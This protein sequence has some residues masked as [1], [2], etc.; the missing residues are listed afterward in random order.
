MKKNNDQ[1]SL[2]LISLIEKYD[3]FTNQHGECYISI[4]LN[5]KTQIW[6]LDSNQLKDWLLFKHYETF[7]NAASSSALNDALAVAHGRARFQS[8][9]IYTNNRFGQNAAYYLD[10]ATPEWQS[11]KMSPGEWT[12]NKDSSSCFIRTSSMR[13]LPLPTNGGDLSTFK[14]F[15][16]IPSQDDFLLVLAYLLECM[17]PDTPFPILLIDGEQGSAKSTTQKYI[18]SIIDP[19]SMTLRV[20]PNSIQDIFVAA[21]NDYI[22]SYNNLSDLSAK[23]QDAICCLSTGGGYSKRKLF[24]DMDESMTDIK[25][26]TILNGIGSIASAS[27]FLD[28][29]ILL[30]L[31]MIDSTTR[32]SEL[33]MQ[34]EFQ[35]AHPSLLGAL[36]DLFVNSL[37]IL[38]SIKLKETPR[39]SDFARLGSAMCIAL[40]QP[41]SKFIQIYNENQNKGNQE[42]IE[43]N[44]TALSILNL[45][46]RGKRE[47]IECNFIQLLNTLKRNEPDTT[48][49]PKNPRSLAS[50]LKRSA[51]ALRRTGIQ[52]YFDPTRRSNGY[53]VTITDERE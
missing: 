42:C 34:E 7:G 46:D 24:T 23:E 36:L 37:A 8:P 18:K 45:L 9:E 53:N 16:N 17:R 11:I 19:S 5:N 26:P 39:M 33:F 44:P 32:K 6:P 51:P 27:D 4:D 48:V 25:R 2:R 40:G 15:L 50:A 20:A 35:Q 3:L 29:C 49:L 22:V 14:Q 10:L 12:I 47:S 31:P 1:P 41:E 30:Q 38:P 21:R 52:I 28:R 43:A 13:P